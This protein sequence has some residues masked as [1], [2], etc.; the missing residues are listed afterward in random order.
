[1]ALTDRVVSVVEDQ[2]LS[3]ASVR[4]QV[5]VVMPEDRLLLLAATI[6]VELL[7]VPMATSEVAIL[8]PHDR[9]SSVEM[10][11]LLGKALARR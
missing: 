11:S 7:H 9:I 1:L 5:C 8:L 10:A 4:A 6:F 3:V 2:V